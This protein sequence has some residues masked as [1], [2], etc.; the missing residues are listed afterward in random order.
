MLQE[1]SV[2]ADF[3][4]LEILRNAW[5]IIMDDETVH[6]ALRFSPRVRE[7]VLETRWHPSQ[8]C[9]DDPE[10][11]GFL[12][13]TA[14]VADTTDMLPWIRGW[15]AE[16]EVLQPERLRQSLA[17]EAQR[18]WAVYGGD[19]AG[20]EEPAPQAVLRSP[21]PIVRGSAKVWR[22]TLRPWRR[23]RRSSQPFG[24]AELA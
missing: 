17:L 13:W 3:P 23:W 8:T 19:Q 21:R 2:P 9:V 20:T 5:S 4:G 14:D 24:A 16:C 22:I 11:P 7:R 12:R 6:V 15:G 1:Y 18:I 10:R